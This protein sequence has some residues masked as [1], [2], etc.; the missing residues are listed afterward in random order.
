MR[1]KLKKARSNTFGSRGA[2][3]ARWAFWLAVLLVSPGG[4]VSPGDAQNVPHGSLQQP[5]GQ[6]VGGS[7]ADRDNGNFDLSQQEVRVQALNRQRQ[8]NIVSDTDKLLK[9]AGELEMEVKSAD[10]DNLTPQQ[11]RKIAEIEKL[12]HSVKDKMSYS[13]KGTVE[14]QQPAPFRT[15]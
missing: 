3:S 13:M 2:H 5:I 10:E 8:K 12:A 9:L 15:H 1:P 7:L 4:A 14:F 11:L 6:P